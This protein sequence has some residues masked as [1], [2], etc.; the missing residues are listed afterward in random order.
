MAEEFD[1]E[2]HIDESRTRIQVT[3]TQEAAVVV[4]DEAGER[5]YLPP[6][7]FNKDT[8]AS[9]YQ[10]VQDDS[11]YQSVPDDSPYQSVQDDSPYQ[12]ARDDSPYQSLARGP[13]VQ[14]TT[15]GFVISHPRPVTEFH[16]FR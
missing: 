15:N 2:T 10:S 7:D 9:P 13:G 8:E 1:C 12:S 14:K 6:E 11:P 5:I 4:R 3:G 16:V